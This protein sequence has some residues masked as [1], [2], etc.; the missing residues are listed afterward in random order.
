MRAT[1][2]LCDAAQA[3]DGKLYILGG[4]WSVSGPLQAP[5]A[6]AIKLEVPWD[7]A[8]E[9]IAWRLHLVDADGRDVVLETNE[10]PRAVELHGEFEVGRPP[11]L[12]PGLPLDLPMAITIVPM[13]LPTGT[14][15]EWLL[16]I[17]GEHRDEWRAGFLVRNPA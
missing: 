7:R 5:T 14:R 13:P 1:I 17:D 4:G 11:G 12:P 16:H 3:I 15:Y 6:I 10:G 2:I 9:R 8:N